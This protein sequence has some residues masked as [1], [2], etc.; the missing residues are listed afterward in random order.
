M[1]FGEY[2]NNELNVILKHEVKNQNQLTLL[3]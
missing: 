3:T 2:L 1:F